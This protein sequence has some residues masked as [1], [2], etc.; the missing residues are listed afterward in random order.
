[1]ETEKLEVSY[2]FLR[3]DKEKFEKL[4]NDGEKAAKN[5]AEQV[6]QKTVEKNK[7]LLEIE[8]VQAEINAVDANC[9]K[10]EDDLTVSKH[11]KKFLDILAIQ[12]N[13]K[14]HKAKKAQRA[15]P[16]QYQP[17]PQQEANNNTTTFLTQTDNATGGPQA[18]NRGR[19][20]AIKTKKL[21]KGIEHGSEGSTLS[22]P[23][24]QQSTMVESSHA[25]LNLNLDDEYEDED[26]LI[27]FRNQDA[28][29]DE[30]QKE[31]DNNLFKINMLQDE[32][33]NVKKAKD[34]ALANID[35]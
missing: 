12:A 21:Q 10:I 31:E 19:P 27:Y 33:Q 8:K 14:E 28:L 11:H 6:K 17:R 25:N 22:L 16:P 20:A 18:T 29:L 2:K 9:K 30:L 35:K 23:N 26:Y 34:M 24:D 4:M 15:A 5:V 13:L 32:E 3:E 1:M 7:L